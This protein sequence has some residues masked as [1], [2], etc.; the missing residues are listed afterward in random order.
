ML[1][2]ALP[3]RIWV[4]RQ[5]VDGRLHFNGLYGLVQSQL[6]SDPLS[7]QLFVFTNRRRNRLKLLYWDG[8]GLWICA[9]RLEKG[10]FAWPTDAEPG[11]AA[12]RFDPPEL[13]RLIQGIELRERRGWYR[14]KVM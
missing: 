13:L 14:K 2:F 12:V 8:P 10:T 1:S 11:G 9:K 3:E 5:P 6:A 4:A 7:G